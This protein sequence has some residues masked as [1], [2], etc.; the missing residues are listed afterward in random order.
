MF[1]Y[2]YYFNNLI[3]F[4][5]NT[6]KN[7]ENKKM[8]NIKLPSVCYPLELLHK[9]L[10][11][12]QSCLTSSSSSSSSSSNNSSNDDDYY[13]VDDY[14]S[15]GEKEK[16]KEIYISKSIANYLAENK[17]A[18]HDNQNEWEKMKKITN[19]FEY[20]NTPLPNMK[21]PICKYKPLSRSYFKMIELVG[22]FQLLDDLPTGN[23]PIYQAPAAPWSKPPLQNPNQNPNPNP[24]PNQIANKKNISIRTMHLAEGPGGFIE[25]M[26]TLRKNPLDIFV[27]M[28][29]INSNDTSVPGW[30]KIN[31]F[32]TK[33]PQI[34]L[35][36]GADQTGNIMNPENIM[37][38]R[39]TFG[40]SMSLVTGDGGFDFSVDYNKQEIL[41][42]KLIFAQICMAIAVLREDGH[43]VV[44]MFD[45]FSRV[46]V[47][48][49]YLL[50]ILF[51]EVHVVKP[52]TS[53]YGNS[54]KYIV[55]KY[56]RATQPV[57]DI[58]LG[59]MVDEVFSCS[60][61]CSSSPNVAGASSLDQC[62]TRIFAFDIPMFFLTKLEGINALLGEQQIN[63]IQT[64]LHLI[65]NKYKTSKKIDTI[66]SKNIQKC[67]A[68]CNEFNV[69]FNPDAKK[70]NI[71]L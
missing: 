52:F 39:T 12:I 36:T 48:M 67:I 50:S 62:L 21:N 45:L 24:N 32:M 26:C 58:L 17:Y 71:F 20:L 41:S 6:K 8:T 40:G 3:F 2:F 54:E 37:H 38:V 63:N 60:K 64:T 19:P 55:C 13:D 44:K 49:L 33:H 35:E 51:A 25:A 15:E 16:E 57:V 65:E 23:N 28:T 47:E 43:F 4:I 9:Q 46:S 29:L 69:P 18:I 53:R 10:H 68:W 70:S 22:T 66:R 30:R 31:Q 61:A 7:R 11:F 34:K 14:I 42:A 5:K 1:L 59:K 56:F 27:G